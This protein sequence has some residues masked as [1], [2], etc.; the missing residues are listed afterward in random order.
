MSATFTFDETKAA[1]VLGVFAR[2]CGGFFDYYL[3]VKALYALDREALLRWGQPVVG[4]AY[5]MLKFGPVNQ[6]FMDATKPERAGYIAT[7]F[8]RSGNEIIMINDPGTDEL[9]AAEIKLAESLC[10]EWKHLTF[11]VAHSKAMSFPE[12]SSVAP[13]EC[14]TPERILQAAG[15][16]DAEIGEAFGDLPAWRLLTGTGA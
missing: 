15:K 1:Q 6:A 4:G 3:A 2:R 13:C 9:S 14:I 7:C 5:R 16:T 10:D 12:C 8:E 11:D